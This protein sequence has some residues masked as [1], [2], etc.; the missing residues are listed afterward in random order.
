MFTP[1]I[2][3]KSKGEERDFIIS[4]PNVLLRHGS[5]QANINLHVV[6]S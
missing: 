6:A 3:F 1:I 2:I 4:R 5:S